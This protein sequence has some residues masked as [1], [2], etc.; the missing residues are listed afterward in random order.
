MG[1]NLTTVEYNMTM[2]RHRTAGT[3]GFIVGTDYGGFRVKTESDGVVRLLRFV[4]IDNWETLTP[5]DQCAVLPEDKRNGE[6]I[7]CRREAV[8]NGT[9][10]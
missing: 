1:R 9:L 3:I 5:C 6:C 8:G 7:T 4:D 10:H 2:I